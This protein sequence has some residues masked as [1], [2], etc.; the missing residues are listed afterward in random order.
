MTGN[1]HYCT[2]DA[3]TRC[4]QSR[5]DMQAL[6]TAIGRCFDCDSDLTQEE[7]EARVNR[8]LE[9]TRIGCEIVSK[10]EAQS[11]TQVETHYS[12]MTDPDMQS[13]LR[14]LNAEII[15]Y[16]RF[17]KVNER[18]QGET[19]NGELKIRHQQQLDQARDD[20]SSFS[21]PQMDNSEILTLL[22]ELKALN[23]MYRCL[24]PEIGKALE[25][26]KNRDYAYEEV[27]DK[28]FAR[29]ALYVAYSLNRYEC[30]EELPPII[31]SISK[32]DDQSEDGVQNG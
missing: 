22:A 6:R 11:E 7:L 8:V 18:R 31:A 1:Q 32:E 4:D 12:R 19:E 23:V 2:D 21:K 16:D 9:I 15:L 30:K 5:L 27:D 13:A 3:G 14:E 20:F 17:V 29:R 26:Y 28:T 24:N 25:R 10:I